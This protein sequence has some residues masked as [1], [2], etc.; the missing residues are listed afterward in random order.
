MPTTYHISLNSFGGTN[1][2][3]YL[4]VSK[5]YVLILIIFWKKGGNYSSDDTN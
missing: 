5:F 2:F 4:N 3:D 1:F